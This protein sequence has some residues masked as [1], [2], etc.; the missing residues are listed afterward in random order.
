MVFWVRGP[1]EGTNTAIKFHCPMINET[2]KNTEPINIGKSRW[3]KCE[4]LIPNNTEPGIYRFLAYVKDGDDTISGIS[5]EKEFTIPSE[6][7]K[8]FYHKCTVI[9]GSEHETG[10]DGMGSSY[11]CFVR[12]T[13]K[14]DSRDG[15]W[16]T[17]WGT[18]T[19]YDVFTYDSE[20][21]R[22]KVKIYYIIM[23]SMVSVSL[24][25]IG[26]QSNADIKIHLRLYD[27]TNNEEV[28]KKLIYSKTGNGPYFNVQINTAEEGYLHADLTKGHTYRVELTAKVSTSG[29]FAAI[30]FADFGA[31]RGFGTKCKDCGVTRLYDEV[32][33]T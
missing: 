18:G 21:H 12:N 20:D 1:K 32:E 8:G 6:T 28:D 10:G 30:S 24:Y 17:H 7:E 2:G 22:N 3:C 16:G 19:D 25:P 33:W 23:G 5:D 15:M 4:W 14:L 13:I 11:V 26:G 29:S 9:E 27:R 31:Y